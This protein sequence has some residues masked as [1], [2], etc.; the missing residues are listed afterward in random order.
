MPDLRSPLAVARDTYLESP[1]GVANK[2]PSTL[3]SHRPDYYLKNRLESAFLAG[4]EFERER[5]DQ[6]LA[7][8]MTNVFARMFHLCP[9]ANQAILDEILKQSKPD[10]Q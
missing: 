9:V 1:E 5:Q 7:K 10:G 2:N 8:R 4:A 3:G 6:E